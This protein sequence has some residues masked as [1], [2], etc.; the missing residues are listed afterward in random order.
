MIGVGTRVLL[1]HC[2][3]GQPGTVIR[4]ERNRAVVLWHDLDFLSRHQPAS[5]VEVAAR[6]PEKSPQFSVGM[7]LSV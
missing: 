1:K 6:S 2:Q 3:H 4:M 5:L 7:E